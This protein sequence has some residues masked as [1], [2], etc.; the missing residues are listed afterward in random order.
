MRSTKKREGGFSDTFD[1]DALRQFKDYQTKFIKENYRSF[2]FR[3]RV[4]RW[5]EVVAW[6]ESQESASNYLL[7][8][9]VKDMRDKGVEPCLYLDHSVS[10]SEAI[11]PSFLSETDNK[12]NSNET[13]SPACLVTL[14]YNK[15]IPASIRKLD[16]LFIA[17]LQTEGSVKILACSKDNDALRVYIRHAYNNNT[18][19]ANYIAALMSIS[20][21]SKYKSDPEF[22]LID[23]AVVFD[24]VEVEAYG[25]HLTRCDIVADFASDN[26]IAMKLNSNQ[27]YFASEYPTM[28][29]KISSNLPQMICV[30]APSDAVVNALRDGT[31]FSVDLS[32]KGAVEA[33]IFSFLARYF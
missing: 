31:K 15:D 33:A 18:V 24:R 30:A 8:L 11:V 2:M 23:H 6:I 22:I 1:G 12:E 29:I 10:L 32:E 16:Q 13:F 28:P 26:C 20:I 27:E 21:T 9:V 25:G 17:S 19:A 7:S 3:P 4:A 5:P 14:Y